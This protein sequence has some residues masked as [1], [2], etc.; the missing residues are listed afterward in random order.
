MTGSI[1]CTCCSALGIGVTKQNANT[2]T[3]LIVA[4]AEE[5][6]GSASHRDQAPVSNSSLFHRATSADVESAVPAARR[7]GGPLA[8]PL[9]SDPPGSICKVSE[10][11]LAESTD[12][13]DSLDLEDSITADSLRSDF[14]TTIVSVRPRCCTCRSR[15]CIIGLVLLF[16]AFAV[17]AGVVFGGMFSGIIVFGPTPGTMAPTTSPAVVT[18]PPTAT[19]TVAPLPK[20]PLFNFLQLLSLGGLDDRGSPQFQAYEWLLN[21]DPIVNADSD[22]ERIKQRY[23]L[24]TLYIATNAE[25]PIW[26]VQDECT[27]PTIECKVPDVPHD[28]FVVE[29]D[30]TLT[31]RINEKQVTHINLGRKALQGTIP[32]EI[33]LLA[34]SLVHLDLSENALH[35]SIPEQLYDLTLLKSLHLTNNTG[36]NGTLSESFGKLQ[37]LEELFLGGNGFGGMMPSNLGSRQGVRPLRK[38]Y[39]NRCIVYVDGVSRLSYLLHHTKG[40]LVLY[41]NDLSGT[42]PLGLNL[43]KLFYMDLSYNNL[44][45]PLPNDIGSNFNSLKQLYLDH[46]R[47]TGTI[48]ESFTEISFGRI[49]VLT[50]ND[51]MLTGGLPTDWEQDNRF[52]L[53]LNVQ[54][55]N[56]TVPIDKDICK[57]SVLEAGELVELGIECEICS[58]ETLCD[59]CY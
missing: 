22:P 55:N 7:Q 15:R 46:N 27:W 48:P 40:Y 57:F 35:G 30:E 13:D 49:Y 19:P 16:I 45:G 6:D 47:L 39:M 54:N 38:Y 17:A 8:K 3:L 37:Q 21:E 33:G 5:S 58:C 34:P 42:I 53:T 24:I 4:M 41:D 14:P 51:N 56:L 20:D 12:L 52:L 10:E 1:E 28:V 2:L 23:A 44:S 43:R 11:S 18:P 32:P 9:R 25:L 26:T 59:K 31:E 50:L 36:M 29:E